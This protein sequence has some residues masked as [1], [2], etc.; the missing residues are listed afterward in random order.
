MSL[1][2]ELTHP[3]SPLFFLTQKLHFPLCSAGWELLW[4]VVSTL[5]CVPWQEG[6]PGVLREQREACG[7]SALFLYSP[8]LTPWSRCHQGLVKPSLGARNS[9]TSAPEGHRFVPSHLL[10]TSSV[11]SA[12]CPL[13][14]PRIPERFYRVLEG[15]PKGRAGN[16]FPSHLHPAG[17]H[18][19]ALAVEVQE[20][21]LQPTGPC[22]GFGDTR[23]QQDLQCTL[24]RAVSKQ[25]HLHLQVFVAWLCLGGSLDLLDATGILVSSC[26]SSLS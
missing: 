15:Q 24:A 11:V 21:A 7:C 1:C 23:G 22:W 20:R 17:Q 14:N 5:L 19:W 25:R 3:A 18:P 2:K 4:Q 13:N 12:Q 6:S 8:E 26:K 16:Q 10:Q 9:R